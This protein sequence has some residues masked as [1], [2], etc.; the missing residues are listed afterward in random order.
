MSPLKRTLDI[1]AALAGL[2][3]LAPVLLVVA[4]LVAVTSKGPALFRQER[5]GKDE[6]TFIC[7]K[8]RTM[9]LGTAHRGTHEIST[10]A[11]TSV[12]AFLRAL[13]LDELPQLW[14][15]FCGEMS[16]V[17][18]R[19]CLLNQK[20]LIAERRKRNVFSVPPGITGLAQVRGVDMS[21]PERLAEIDQSYIRTRSL[22][23]DLKL[24][25]RTIFR[26]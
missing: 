1:T 11:L 13:K 12:G 4:V 8:F 15:V 14:N 6:R 3:L 21:E 19:P 5:I 10:G 20:Q 24:I 7:N 22:G 17:G 23:M 16:L 2:I 26:L 25:F 9:H 18:P